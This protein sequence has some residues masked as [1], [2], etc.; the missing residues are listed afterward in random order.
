VSARPPSHLVGL[1]RAGPLLVYRSASQRREAHLAAANEHLRHVIAILVS[2]MGG[3]GIVPGA[4][5]ADDFDL[6]VQ[7]NP[8]THDILYIAKPVEKPKET[9]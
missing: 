4:A 6:S 7:E 9:T 1:P 8:E 3:L 5:L 2:Q